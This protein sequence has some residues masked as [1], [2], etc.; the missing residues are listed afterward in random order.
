MTRVTNAAPGAGGPRVDR[1]LLLAGGALSVLLALPHAFLGW[2]A[3]AAQ[4]HLQTVDPDLV[5]GLAVGWFSG[6]I[7]G[8]AMHARRAQSS[9]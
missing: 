4:L 3:I 1:K 5:E 7:S 9:S 8:A 6:L 2:P